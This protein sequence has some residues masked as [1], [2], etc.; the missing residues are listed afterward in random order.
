MSGKAFPRQFTFGWYELEGQAC[1][2]LCW[3]LGPDLSLI[4]HAVGFSGLPTVVKLGDRETLLREREEKKRVSP[5]R[6]PR[7]WEADAAGA[8]VLHPRKSCSRL[9]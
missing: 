7:L 3:A 9:C 5:M 6:S 4:S 8:H 2:A 1:L